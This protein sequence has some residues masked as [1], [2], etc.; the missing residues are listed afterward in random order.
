MTKPEVPPEKF[1]PQP[2]QSGCVGCHAVSR[3]GTVVAVR[4]E[5]SNMNY[6]NAIDVA[7][8]TTK[9]PADTEQWNFSAIHPNNTDM[10]VT[11]TDGIYRIDLSTGTTTPLYNAARISHPDVSPDGTHI[12]AT[13][14][15]AGT[16]VW[17]SASDLVVFDYDATAKTV[18][19]PRVLVAQDGAEYPYYPSFS[20]DN[21]WVLYNRAPSGDSYNNAHA[22]LWVTRADGT[23]TPV[24]L[25]EAEVADSY[26][27]WPKWTPFAVDEVTATGSEPVLWLTVASQR[28]FGV[29][30]S[31]TQKPQLWLAPFYPQRAAA[32]QPAS[33]PAIRLPFQALNEGNHIAQWTEQ[34]VVLQ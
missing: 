8:L 14:T 32:G 15:K 1:W 3:D 2:G 29:R 5:G 11:K 20:P 12:V 4:Q 28:P 21:Q 22:E 31:G 33:G 23:G 34:I 17:T 24:R 9:L 30:S 7:Q 13:Q 16:E 19:A 26:D 27:S 25:Q 6:G 18:G 10:F